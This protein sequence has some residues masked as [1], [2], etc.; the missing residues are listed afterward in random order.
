VFKELNQTCAFA[1]SRRSQARP[2]Q[3]EFTKKCTGLENIRV[4][5]LFAI[6]NNMQGKHSSRQNEEILKRLLAFPRVSSEMKL[7]KSKFQIPKIIQPY[8]KFYY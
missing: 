7:P 8:A 2:T 1:T 4:A 3:N 6:N 5:R